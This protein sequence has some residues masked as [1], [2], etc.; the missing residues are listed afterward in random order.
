MPIYE[1]G[2]TVCGNRF[3]RLRS[4][5]QMD[6][7]APCPECDSESKRQLSV[8]AAF[9]SNSDGQMSAVTGGGCSAGSCAGCSAGSCPA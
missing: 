6:D 9:S 3:E 5:S 4:M 7:E 8:F 1:Y 2:C